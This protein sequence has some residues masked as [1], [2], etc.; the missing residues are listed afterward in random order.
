MKKILLVGGGGR[1]HAIALSIA[2]ELPQAEIL[3]CQDCAIP[4]LL[5]QARLLPGEPL[6]VAL[7]EAP[8]LVIVGPE[9][10]LVAGLVNQLEEAGLSV[11]GPPQAVARLEGSKSF[12]K[13]FMRQYGVRSP[14]YQV[15]DQAG[16]ALNYLKGLQ[17]TD[18]P[19]VLKADGLAGGK[20]VLICEQ[21]KA[22]LQG[23]RSLMQ[24]RIFEDAG[25]TVVIEQYLEGY[26]ASVLAFCDGSSIRPM[27]G[28]KDH[29][30]I[31]EGERGANTGGMGCIAPHP[32][33]RQGTA[34][35]QDFEQ[36][37]VDPTLRGIQE[38]GWDFCG[39]IFFGLMIREPHSAADPL[40][41]LLEYNMRLGDPEAQTLLPLLETPLLQIIESC[42][43]GRLADQEIRWRAAHS[44][45]VVAAAEN[46]PQSPVTGDSIPGLAAATDRQGLYLNG[47]GYRN[48]RFYTDGGRVL[49]WN[50]T[51]ARPEEAR[52][53]AYRKLLAH[54]FR[55]MQYRSDIGG[56][57]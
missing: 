57:A 29:K 51:G 47:T 48:G 28:A 3:L 35:W 52:R 53:E 34:L 9:A 54:P 55:G 10:P 41:Y 2:T 12:A 36:N 1:E 21:R 22:A 39:I 15:F 6:Q 40:C 42:L 26:E 24:D 31:L 11:F 8:D 19:I 32:R 4:Q 17:E 27:P 30:K 13:D 33:F 38:R 37:I 7:Q 5:P 49:A 46:Y 23:I 45:T 43:M 16:A 14:D 56:P 20:G 44:C 25:R 18:F 50:A